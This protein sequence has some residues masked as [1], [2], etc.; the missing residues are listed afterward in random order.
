[1]CPASTHLVI[2]RVLTD[3]ISATCFR[4]SSFVLPV[5]VTVIPRG[6]FAVCLVLTGEILLPEI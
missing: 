6:M 4:V 2:V 1:M 3:S 5:V